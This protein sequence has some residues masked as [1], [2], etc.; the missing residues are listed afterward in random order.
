[1]SMALF[2]DLCATHTHTHTHTQACLSRMG[3]LIRSSHEHQAA[4]DENQAPSGADAVPPS[5][6]HFITT[7]TSD[8]GVNYY[9]Y[10]ISHE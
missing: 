3:R 10:H 4:L 8:G 7:A 9:I 6:P 5:P 1:M 2:S